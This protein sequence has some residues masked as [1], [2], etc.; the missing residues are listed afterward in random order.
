MIGQQQLPLAVSFLLP[1]VKSLC[2]GHKE[3]ALCLN[4]LSSCQEKRERNGSC[5]QG[6]QRD[7]D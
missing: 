6:G 3:M 2:C 4:K 1:L 5:E 7:D